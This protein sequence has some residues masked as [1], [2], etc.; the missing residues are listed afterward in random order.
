LM[1]PSVSSYG[2]TG[3]V[4]FS[5]RAAACSG[6]GQSSSD[7]SIA[8]LS[9]SPAPPLVPQI[10]GQYQSQYNRLCRCR[11]RCSA[12]ITCVSSGAR[13]EVA[14]RGGREAERCASSITPCFWLSPTFSL[15]HSQIL[16]A[17]YSS[18]SLCR[19]DCLDHCASRAGLSGFS[20]VAA[21]ADDPHASSQ[22]RFYSSTS[23]RRELCT[24]LITIP[25]APS[26]LYRLSVCNPHLFA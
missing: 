19:D 24:T 3:T 5:S 13:E 12:D 4:P 15:Q 18:R 9:A 23:T 21:T 6:K 22:R 14:E 16:H 20:C 1:S 11:H 25:S 2:L 26:L 17:S 8:H 10:F 7:V